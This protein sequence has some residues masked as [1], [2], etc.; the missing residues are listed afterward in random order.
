MLKPLLSHLAL[1]FF[2]DT[3]QAQSPAEDTN[4]LY[5]FVEKNPEFPGG[6]KMMIDLIQS[7]IQYPQMEKDN[8]IEGKVFVSFVIDTNGAVSDVK[9]TKKLSPGLDKEAVR[10]VKQLPDFIPGY[11]RGKPARV[12]L[13]VPVVFKL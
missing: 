10:V 13:M 8:H 5:T 4:K 6:D 2:I 12:Q 7:K 1:L 11:H 3:I 9:V